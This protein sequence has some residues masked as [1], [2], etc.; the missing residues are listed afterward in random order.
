[1]K[2]FTLAPGTLTRHYL[3][4]KRKVYTP[5]V[6]Y[7]LFGIAFY[8]IMRW[9][10]NW[11]PVVS[12]VQQSTGQALPDTPTMQVNL[13]MSRNVNLLLPLWI[14]MLATFDRI[15]FPR[16]GLSWVERAVH[17][18]FAVGSYIL[19]SSCMIP[20]IKLWPA[21]HLINFVIIF[22]MI[23]WA[24]ANLHGSGTV[25]WVKAVLI[26]PVSFFLYVLLASLLV[27]VFLGVPVSALMQR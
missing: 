12:A 3:A 7:F 26:V 17:Y 24:I 4:G 20:L 16:A 5:P 23:I 11:D 27:A 8:F 2:E 18:L 14:G 25:A 10:L 21:L 1:M 6:R 13:W 15:L 9:L 19:L 22:G